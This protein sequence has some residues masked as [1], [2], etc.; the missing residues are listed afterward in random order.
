M[1]ENVTTRQIAAEVGISQTALFPY[2]ATRDEMLDALAE[3][4]WVGLS[5]ALDVVARIDDAPAEPGLRLRALLAAF[6]RYWLR[7]ADDFRVV[8]MRRAMRAGS[9]ELADSPGRKLLER[10]A[11]RVKAGVKAGSVREIHCCHTTA[12]SMWSAAAGIVSLRLAYPDFPWP[13]EEEHI[14]A[15][16]DMIFNGCGRAQPPAGV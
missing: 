11:E 12:L 3:E 9:Q 10:L 2:F 8:F 7:H 15:T 4:A 5:D 16:L 6:M 13:P 14:E 1:V